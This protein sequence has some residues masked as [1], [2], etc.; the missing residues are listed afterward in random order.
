MT[1]ANGCRDV[2]GPD[3]VGPDVVG[4]DV[5]GP[6]KDARR[7]RLLGD[8]AARLAGSLPVALRRMTLRAGDCEIELDLAG[9]QA[10]AKVGEQAAGTVAPP[11]PA[12]SQDPDPGT[13]VVRAP[14]VGTFYAAPSPGAAAF[15][16]VGD[17][18]EIGQQLCIVEAMKLMNPI[19][20]DH[21]GTVLE[22]LARDGEPVEYDQPLLVLNP[23]EAP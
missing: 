18:V 6:D 11:V 8:A 22:V 17:Q 23:A 7:L 1:A 13:V 9:E 19:T 4:P 14:L 15:V 2:V 16:T 20:A 12:T 3:V 21:F 10:G 5:V